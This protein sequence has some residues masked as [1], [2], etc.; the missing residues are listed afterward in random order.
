MGEVRRME[1]MALMVMGS[2]GKAVSRDGCV[3][4]PA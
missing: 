2:Q 1:V 3:H 4:K